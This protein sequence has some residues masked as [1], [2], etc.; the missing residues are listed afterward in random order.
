MVFAALVEIQAVLPFPVLGIDSDNGSEFINAHLFE[1]CTSNHITFTRG[2]AGQSNDGAHIEQKNWTIAR[3]TAG[4]WRYDTPEQQ[5]LLNQMW[6]TLSPITNLYTP[7]AKL[8][9]RHRDGAR[10]VKTHDA[11]ATPLDR[12]LDFTDLLDPRDIQAVQRAHDTL[13]LLTQ[14]R[15]VSDLQSRLLDLVK[16]PQITRRE[17]LGQNYRN[18]TKLTHPTRASVDESTNHPKRAS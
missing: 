10:V 1:Y 18:K 4:Y 12:L 13:D 16:R 3:R 7:S 14:R 8:I 2:R 15:R 17:Q 11:P 9:H 5:R 6:T